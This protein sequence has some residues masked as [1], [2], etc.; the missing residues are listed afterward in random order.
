MKKFIVVK[1]SFFEGMARVVDIGGTLEDECV[2]SHHKLKKAIVETTHKYSSRPIIN[3]DDANALASDWNKVSHDLR[4]S[5]KQLASKYLEQ[6]ASR[7]N[8]N[9][10]EVKDRR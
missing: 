1:P 5:A 6:R 9:Q 4:V 10:T 7:A 2:V 3:E 8:T